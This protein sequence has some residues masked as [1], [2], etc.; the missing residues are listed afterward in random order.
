MYTREHAYLQK[1][2][3]FILLVIKDLVN[4][5]YAYPATA[6]YTIAKI[7]NTRSRL[8]FYVEDLPS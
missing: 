2:F 5:A 3:V 6:R 8:C 4:P 1:L 7:H